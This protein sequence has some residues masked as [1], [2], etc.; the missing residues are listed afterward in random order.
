MGNNNIASVER[1]LDV[2]L[3]LYG[4]GKEM[5][6]SEIA[7]HLG[8]YKSTIY[9]TLVTL[10]EKHFIQKNENTDKYWLGPSL[11]T[12]G[13][14]VASTYSLVDF[15]APEADALYENV[16]DVV[17]V[18]ILHVDPL[19]GY[20]SVVIY[21]SGGSQQILGINPGIGSG[22]EAYASAV[23][24]CMLAFNDIDW[25][26]IEHAGFHAYTGNTLTH[27]D[28]LRNNLKQVREN[29]YAVD[30]EEREIGLFCVGVPIFNKYGHAIAAVSISGPKERVCNANFMEKLSLLKRCA[31][32]I[33]LSTKEIKET[34]R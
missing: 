33:S 18:S 1:A 22:M 6:V 20:R 2:L 7:G 30:N 17:N 28:A 4:E 10:Q 34:I 32:R 26:I 11:Y 5:G 15:V 31:Q 9:R 29:G 14:M 21:K 16:K 25:Q 12:I 8:L 23:G 3:L 13:M 27:A 19:N 24:K